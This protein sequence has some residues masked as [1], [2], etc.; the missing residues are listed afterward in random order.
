[1]RF[2]IIT[3]FPESF[4]YLEES[5]IKRAKSSGHIEINIHDLRKY[6]TDKHKKVDDKPFGGG[7][8]MLIQVEPVYNALKDL[9]VY[10]PAQRVKLGP[11]IWLE[12]IAHQ[13]SES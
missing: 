11:K 6:S 3:L 13:W 9:G 5:I 1:M 8:G 12:N 4:S 2:D 10:L 7:A